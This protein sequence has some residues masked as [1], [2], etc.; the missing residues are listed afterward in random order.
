MKPIS[1]I[2]DTFYPLISNLLEHNV[3][4]GGLHALRLHGLKTRDPEDF[5]LIVYNPDENQLA[6]VRQHDFTGE[7]IPKE[8]DDDYDEPDNGDK[9]RSYK[10]SKSEMV[11][12]VLM[13]FQHP[14]EENLLLFEHNGIQYQVQSISS[15]IDAK[16]RYGRDKDI[17]DINQLAIF[18]FS[19]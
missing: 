5:D 13:E 9:R 3:A 19:V 2:L 6:W 16:R 15:V 14:F 1:E 8:E 7:Q 12:N 4:I 18:N 10:F 17:E 11:L